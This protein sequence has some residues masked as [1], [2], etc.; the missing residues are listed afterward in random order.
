MTCKFLSLNLNSFEEVEVTCFLVLI[1]DDAAD[2]VRHGAS[3][4]GHQFVQ[5]LLH[6]HRLVGRQVT[7]GKCYRV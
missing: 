2:K 5:R 7:T 1:R 6:A 4:G 3:Q